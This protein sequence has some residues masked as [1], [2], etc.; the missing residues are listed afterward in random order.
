MESSV[1]LLERDR[2][3]QSAIMSLDPGASAIKASSPSDPSDEGKRS[4][5]DP[6]AS[7]APLPLLKVK[8]QDEVKTAIPG[9]GVE[10]YKPEAVRT[11]KAMGALGLPLALPGIGPALS[12]SHQ[13]PFTPSL[14]GLLEEVRKYVLDSLAYLEGLVPD[15]ELPSAVFGQRNRM[16]AKVRV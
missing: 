8:G 15:W 14:P 2:L 13:A 12:S 3:D 4:G 5:A 6:S 9:D 11:R 16:I 1:A 10:A 7:R